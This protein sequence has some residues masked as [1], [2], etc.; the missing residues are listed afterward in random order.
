MR[1]NAIRPYE[2]LIV[3]PLEEHLHAIA[4]CYNEAQL[5]DHILQL[6]L[7]DVAQEAEYFLEQVREKNL[8][9]NAT[10]EEALLGARPLLDRVD[11]TM[12]LVRPTMKR[13]LRNL[14]AVRLFQMTAGQDD[15]D[16]QEIENENEDQEYVMDMNEEIDVEELTDATHR[17]LIPPM[18]KDV[19]FELKSKWRGCIQRWKANFSRTKGRP[20]TVDDMWVISTERNNYSMVS[21]AYKRVKQ[22]SKRK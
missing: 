10:L 15:E 22:H 14:Q 9:P 4:Q 1:V 11:E 20:P 6:T 3:T 8:M 7:L 18:D 2:F 12:A 16:S 5:A 17:A 21:K 13:F 19:L